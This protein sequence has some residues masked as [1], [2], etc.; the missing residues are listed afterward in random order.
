MPEP[1]TFVYSTV[2]ECEIH[3]D[4]YLPAAAPASQEAPLALPVV[5]FFHGGG[6]FRGSRKSVLPELKGILPLSIS[7][8]FPHH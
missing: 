4:L 5:L 2:N 7:I 8:F 6:V 3:L 1:Q